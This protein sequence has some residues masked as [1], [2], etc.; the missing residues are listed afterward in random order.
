[1]CKRRR[2]L[3]IAAFVIVFERRLAG[4]FADL[5]ADGCASIAGRPAQ[6][7][8][9]AMFLSSD[10]RARELAGRVDVVRVEDFLHWQGRP[11]AGR[12]TLSAALQG[13]S[14][15]AGIRALSETA[16]PNVFRQSKG[17]PRPA[18]QCSSAKRPWRSPPFR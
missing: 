13:C 9:C 12:T 11:S 3:A 2:S 6:A 4:W 8:L 16:I 1:I 10:C 18:L 14:V 15:L 7:M 5:E 17:R